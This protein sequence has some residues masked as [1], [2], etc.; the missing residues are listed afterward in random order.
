MRQLTGGKTNSMLNLF[1]IL[2]NK[3]AENLWHLNL[4]RGRRYL[5]RTAQRHGLWCRPQSFDL[6]YFWDRKL[7]MPAKFKNRNK[8]CFGFLERRKSRTSWPLRLQIVLWN[9]QPLPRLISIQ[10]EWIFVQKWPRKMAVLKN[11]SCFGSLASKIGLYRG[12]L[13]KPAK[14]ASNREISLR[15]WT[16]STT[17]EI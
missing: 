3:I 7:T 13:A 2:R 14:E 15:D 12:W 1:F 8:S 17:E 4:K 6:W 5:R 9:F 11:K 10:N 16:L